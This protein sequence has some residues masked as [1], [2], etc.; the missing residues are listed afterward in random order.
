VRACAYDSATRMSLLASNSDTESPNLLR[1]E[2][3]RL[4]PDTTDRKPIWLAAL[5]VCIFIALATALHEVA[6]HDHDSWVIRLLATALFGVG[7]VFATF[8]A[9][10]ERAASELG[11]RTQ[12]LAQRLDVLNRTALVEITDTQGRIVDANDAFCALSGYGREEL[13]GKTHQLLSSGHHPRA[14][15]MGMRR[16]ITLGEVWRG[17]ICNKA[18]DGSLYWTDTTI[19]PMRDARGGI[20]SYTSIRIDITARKAAEASLELLNERHSRIIE[21]SG[22]CL[23]DWDLVKDTVSVIGPWARMLGF[24]DHELG[25]GPI[26][27]LHRFMAAEDLVKVSG[28]LQAHAHGETPRFQCEARIQNKAGHYQ[29]IQLRGVVIERDSN[30]LA[31]RASGQYVDITATKQ[32]AERSEQ[33]EALLKTIIDVLPQRVFWKDREGRFL[34]ANRGLREDAAMDGVVGKTDHDMPWRGE[35]ADFF[36]ETDRKIMASRVP[37]INLI[38][39]LTRADGVA[40]WLTTSKVPLINARGEVWGILGTYQD[41]TSIKQTEMELMAA[42]D[43]AERASRAKSEFLATMSH[44]IRTPMNGI[45]GFTS[46]LLDTKL[47]GEQRG[48]AETIRDSSGA[49]LAIIDDI[50][51]F[52][53]IAAGRVSVDRDP[54]DALDIATE[55]MSLLRPRAAEKRITFRLDWQKSAPRYLLGD[56]GRFR[57]VLVN[58]ASNAVKFTESGHVIVRAR[59]DGDLGWIEIEDTG[60]G[61]T[62]EQSERLFTKFTQADSSTTRK[63]GGTGLGLA[64]SKQLVE[65][66]GGT[67]GVNSTPACGSTFW[68]T[69]PIATHSMT[70]RVVALT[71][72]FVATALT[73]PV[74]IHVLDGR[75]H[76]LVAE[77]NVV[78]CK[79]AVRMLGKLGCRVDVAENGAVALQRASTTRYDLILMDCQMPELDGFEATRAIRA[80]E[81]DAGVHT[82]IVALTANVTV[83]DRERCLEAGMDGHLSKPFSA[84]DFEKTVRQ[85]CK[86]D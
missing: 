2:V 71:P 47:D 77:D 9:L 17:E 34:G 82:P 19:V 70:S 38:E 29:W 10:I 35:Q 85:W 1:E 86:P 45:M 44:E 24:E 26:D 43:A 56:P 62:P 49:L 48:F 30:G 33:S 53:K 5:G 36:R 20:A 84:T 42:R 46:F 31:L 6:V 28:A 60:I 75:P 18:K 8:V 69:M 25:A 58:L 63:Y 79:L 59:G 78:N 4:A 73:V 11:V 83:E 76:V 13:L 41:I 12:L 3:R 57:Q 39:P 32:A 67:I 72:D 52:S 66:M 50:L 16:M 51:D 65:L 23:W 7:C 55:V 80:R 21:G 64:I 15:F 61:V 40:T 81:S 27:T 54:F 14:F 68:F 74:P 37:V 22:V